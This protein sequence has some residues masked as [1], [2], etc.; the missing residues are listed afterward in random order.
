MKTAESDSLEQYLYKWFLFARSQN[1]PING[2][3]LKEKAIFFA[4]ELNIQDF[5]ASNGWLERWKTRNKISFKTMA[6]EA[7]SCTSEMT[8]SRK[9]KV[10]PTIL[11]NYRPEDIYN[12]DEFD[13]SIPPW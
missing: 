1:I 11:S 5:A 3:I 13:L 6:C 4:K 8:A 2:I 7:N 10:L 9:E 12:A